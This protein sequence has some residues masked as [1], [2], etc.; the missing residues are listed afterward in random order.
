MIN[1]HIQNKVEQFQKMLENID[2]RCEK[3]STLLQFLDFLDIEETD[4]LMLEISSFDYVDLGN[5][6]IN[7]GGKFNGLLLTINN[8]LKSKEFIPIFKIKQQTND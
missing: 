4:L 7:V 2:E 3:T 1:Q 8:K 6:F 5:K